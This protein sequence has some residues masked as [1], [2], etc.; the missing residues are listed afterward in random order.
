M[1]KRNYKNRKKKENNGAKKLNLTNGVTF[2]RLLLIPCIMYF[3]L[4]EE[5]TTALFLLI[6]A[7]LSDA[8]DGHLARKLQQS[9]SFGKRF[10]QFTDKILLL[11]VLF[12]LLLKHGSVLWIFVYVFAIIFS[13]IIGVII[14][15]KN[16]YVTSLNKITM[17][18]Q[19]V[20]LLIM[21][22]GFIDDFMFFLFFMLLLIPAVHYLKRTKAK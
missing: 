13:I 14:V 17:V 12:T 21:V 3:L 8:I 22:S 2:L 19:S 1:K 4:Q 9:S 20:V 10:D 11:A 18:L 6:A 5:N 16:L 15:K 7:F